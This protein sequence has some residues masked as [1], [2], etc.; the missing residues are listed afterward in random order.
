MPSAKKLPK[1]L[2]SRLTELTK[3]YAEA[4]NSATAILAAK[5]DLIDLS[6]NIA[7]VRS[8]SEEL[9]LLSQDLTRV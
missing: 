9:A 4:S 8:G 1:H 3:R 6:R 5:T 2:I 7:Q